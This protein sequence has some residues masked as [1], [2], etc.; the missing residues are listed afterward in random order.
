MINI[1]AIS[2]TGC[3]LQR[4]SLYVIATLF[5]SSHFTMTSSV[6][7]FSFQYLNK[8]DR[9]SCVSKQVSSL[10]KTIAFQEKVTEK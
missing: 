3:M 8:T 4:E 1:L 5:L 6:L 9:D 10:E 7:L 2:V